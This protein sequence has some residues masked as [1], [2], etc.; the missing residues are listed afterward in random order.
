MSLDMKLGIQT[1]SCLTD[2]QLGI[3]EL[4]FIHEKGLVPPDSKRMQMTIERIKQLGIQS[5][6]AIR[7]LGIER[8][9]IV[10]QVGH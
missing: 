4:A 5:H 2:I 1:R 3:G 10:M 7:I 6:T 8:R 9:K